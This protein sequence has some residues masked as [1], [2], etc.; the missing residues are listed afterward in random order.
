MI[1]L[2]D[3]MYKVGKYTLDNEQTAI[4]EDSSN[5]LLV[6]AGAG[7]GKTLTILGKIKYL[8]EERNI[9]PNE[10]LCIS[11]TRKASLSLEEK[12]KKD[13][14]LSVPVYTFH[15]LALDILKDNNYKIADS[16]LLEDIIHDFFISTIINYPYQ[17]K[18]IRKYFH[19]KDYYKIL[20][21]RDFIYLERNLS[22]FIHLLKCNGYTILD[23]KY[24]FKKIRF[25]LSYKKYIEEKIFLLL[26]INILLIYNDY[27]SD[28]HEIDFDD[29][30]IKATEYIKNNSYD[31]KIK[32]IIIDEYQDTSFIRFNLVKELLD[33]TKSKLMVVGD[34]FQSI[35]HF[36]GCELD[37][38]LNFKK[39]FKD[40]KLL[41]IQ[42]TY[43]NSYELVKIAGDFIMKNPKQIKKKLNSNKH[44]DNP[45]RII[46]Y[47]SV[48]KKI[49]E[50]IKDTYNSTNKPILILGRNNNDIE[51][52]LD[53]DF[54]VVEDKVIYLPN[55]NIDINY[56]TIHKSK[57]LECDNV[58]MINL[59]NSYLGLPSK[60]KENKILRLVSNN[61]DKYLYS[62][63]RRLFYVGLTRTK[64][65]TYLLVPKKNPSM[66]IEEIKKVCYTM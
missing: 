38:F 46:Y 31:K 45:I 50:L 1:I 66:F 56:M 9:N 36:T 30:I 11:F 34:D 19:E 65:Y 23:F 12:I 49:K 43:R 13:L 42:T 15:K 57:G 62:E 63:E 53:N 48:K 59:S 58:I 14:N 24:F 5:H 28:N 20:K 7:S 40:S 60:I 4:V 64:N 47:D 10:I 25:T 2:G 55:K 21:R 8:V 32:Y 33:K 54:K 18:L 44:L 6:V 17:M 26:A 29:M 22:T 41:K 27:L 52:V 16:N 61:T 3:I 51:Y 35:Y 39:Y 37:L